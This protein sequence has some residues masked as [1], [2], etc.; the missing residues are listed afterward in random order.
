MAKNNATNDATQLRISII[1]KQLL[2]QSQTSKE[3][4]NQLKSH[5]R[6][7]KS[8]TNYPAFSDNQQIFPPENVVDLT[9]RSPEKFNTQPHIQKNKKPKLQWDTNISQTLQYN[10]R[11]PPTQ[12]F[13][14][15]TT[16]NPFS[17]TTSQTP[18]IS[19]T[20]NTAIHPNSAKPFY[21][22]N[23]QQLKKTS[24]TQFHSGRY[25]GGRR[26]YTQRT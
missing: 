9:L 13:S 4:L 23:L 18:F 12:M 5:K 16:L 19:N 25:K 8:K 3:I 20:H 15:S 6:S 21:G 17:R 24:K 10:Q 11:I 1:E 2:Q 22:Y 14:H 7:E 26:G